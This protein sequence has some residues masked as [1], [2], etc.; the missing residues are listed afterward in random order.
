MT[1]SVRQSG[2]GLIEILITLVIL[3]IGLLGVASLQFV[4]SFANK[5]AISRTQS[6]LVAQQVAERLR[7]ATR[8]PVVGDGLVVH[9]NYFSTDT[10]NFSTLSCASGSHPYKCFCLTRPTDVP[11]C[12]DG[13]CNEAEM[14]EYDGW[15]LSCSAVQTNPQTRL[16]VSCT[17]NKVGDVDV[18]SAGSRIQIMLQW[19]VSSSANRQYTLNSRCNPVS[20]DSFAC[21]FKDIT[22]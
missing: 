22:L 14:A 18:C 13:E 16:S 12:E 15:A 19:P 10:Y 2:V 11:N 1:R 3:A 5:D 21:V 8:A 7:A 20:G 6:E 17:D 4:G 9:N